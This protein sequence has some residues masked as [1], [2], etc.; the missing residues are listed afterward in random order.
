MTFRLNL[1]YNKTIESLA[2]TEVECIIP[3]TQQQLEKLRKEGQLD[4]EYVA[5]P[6]IAFA[7]DVR[8]I[9]YQDMKDGTFAKWWTDFYGKDSIE[10][11]KYLV[12]KVPIDLISKEEPVGAPPHFHTVKGFREENIVSVV[13]YKHTAEGTQMKFHHQEKTWTSCY[14]QMIQEPTPYDS[15]DT[16]CSCSRILESA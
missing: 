13:E 16:L 10:D 4:G 6:T 12:V 5:I 8:H 1:N 9:R 2:G 15:N 3:L 14:T 7:E 11:C